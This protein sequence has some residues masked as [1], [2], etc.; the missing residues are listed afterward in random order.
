M[1]KQDIHLANDGRGLLLAFRILFLI[2][3]LA[4]QFSSMGSFWVGLLCLRSL[5]YRI[6]Y[7]TPENENYILENGLAPHRHFDI[8]RTVSS[9]R[10]VLFHTCSGDKSC[11]SRSKSLDHRSRY[12]KVE[13][14]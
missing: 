1:V 2:F 10:S 6:T 12:Y 11:R 5:G 13:K 7:D 9:L 14:I 8:L 4:Q 3:T